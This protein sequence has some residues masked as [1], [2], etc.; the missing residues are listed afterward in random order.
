MT[1]LSRRSFGLTMMGALAAPKAFSAGKKYGPG[2]SDTE[3]VLGQTQPYSG[4]ASSYGTIGRAEMAYFD[5]VNA[6]GGING[7]KVRLIS[8]DDA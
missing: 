7:R 4:G 2:V 1:G 6:A 8:L 3:I 5:M